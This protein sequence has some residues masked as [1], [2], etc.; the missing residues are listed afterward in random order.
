MIPSGCCTYCSNS[1]GISIVGAV[2]V[3]AGKVPAI[4]SDISHSGNGVIK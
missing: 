1:A 4:H 3:I 2:H